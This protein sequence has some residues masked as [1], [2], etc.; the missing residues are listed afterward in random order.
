MAILLPTQ[1]DTFEVIVSIDSA[2]DSTPEQWEKYR[3]TLDESHLSFKEG[4]EPTR[5]VMRRVL[6]FALDK[7]V[8]NEKVT[9][10]DG[11]ME[12]QLGFISEEVRASLV[13]IKNP[14][15]VPQEQWIKF[16]KEKDGGASEKLMELLSA[17]S[18]VDELFSARQVKVIRTSDLLK[19]K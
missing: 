19:K 3:E 5:F 13:D 18:I 10:K 11:K 1:K 14:A 16:E 8:Q 2:L 17:V 6:P 9:T 7:K 12:V 15:D 4:M